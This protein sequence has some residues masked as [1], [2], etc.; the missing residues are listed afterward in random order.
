MKPPALFAM[1]A[2][3]ILI[4]GLVAAAGWSVA[5]PALQAAAIRNAGLLGLLPLAA[6]AAVMLLARRRG[7][8]PP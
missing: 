6:A 8:G 2:A 4:T 1:V 7:G 5:S 3:A